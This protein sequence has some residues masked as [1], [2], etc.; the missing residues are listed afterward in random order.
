MVGVVNA[1]WL[2]T[3][4]TDTAVNSIVELTGENEKI[5]LQTANNTE[6][7]IVGVAPLTFQS[8]DKIVFDVP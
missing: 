6:L 2:Q 8:E 5:S 1:D 3:K 7:P 4:F